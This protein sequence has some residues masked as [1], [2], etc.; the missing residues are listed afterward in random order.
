M[1]TDMATVARFGAARLSLVAVATFASGVVHADKWLIDP[2]VSVSETY[3]TNMLFNANTK[4]SGLISDVAPGVYVFGN[5]ARVKANVNYRLDNT[6]YQGH[7][8]FNQ[9]LNL[10]GSN[11][12]INAIDNWLYVDAVANIDQRNVSAFSA[13][14]ADASGG[15]R[16]RTETNTVQLSPYIR[17]ALANTATYQLRYAATQSNSSDATLAN[18]KINQ[19]VGSLK[20]A[21]AGARVGWS[22]DADVIHARNSLVGGLEDSRF[23]GALTYAV[24]P[25]VTVS[26][27][28]GHEHTNYASQ[29][30]QDLTTP[31]YGINW[32]PSPRTQATAV[33]E[34]RF[35]GTGHSILLTHRT[36]WTAW[37]YSDSKDGNVLSS[38]LA[39]SRQGGLDQ[40]MSDLLVAS[41]TD[42]LER[43]RTVRGLVDRTST[44]AGM[45][46][47]AVQTSRV[48]VDRLRRGAVVFL[49]RRDTVALTIDR[50]DEHALTEAPSVSDSFSLSNDIKQSAIGSTW[51]HRL[52]RL[53]S[54]DVAVA[55]LRSEGTGMGPDIHSVQSAEA[56]SLSFQLSPQS[57]ASLGVRTVRFDS[58]VEG[59][60]RENAVLGA[61]VHHFRE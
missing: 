2:Y 55:R 61:F 17:G 22:A 8:E 7:P 57:N 42:P 15:P 29:S 35:F 13:R 28:D 47:E 16:S 11:A 10:L 46:A 5:G 12:T 34:K 59:N 41:I 33:A 40:L 51:S 39:S 36:A 20:N 32:S 26:V 52:T 27:S 24:I 18:T 60:F 53:L 45:S 23:R 56:L 9:S 1:G 6:Y 4:L 31:G 50:T 19:W 58:N 43:A 49:G 21:S 25:Q 44:L 54:F 30:P 48:F 37:H 14:V 38:L 3:S